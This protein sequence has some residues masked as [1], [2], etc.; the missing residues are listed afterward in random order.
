MT[1]QAE[2]DSSLSQLEAQTSQKAAAFL[3]CHNNNNNNNNTPTTWMAMMSHHHLCLSF[4][5][6]LWSLKHQFYNKSDNNNIIKSSLSAAVGLASEPADLHR[7]IIKCFIHPV[8]SLIWLLL[9]SAFHQPVQPR[10]ACRQQRAKRA[11]SLRSVAQVRHTADLPGSNW[12]NSLECSR[13]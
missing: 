6:Q 10:K 4:V 9:D 3:L 7:L 2:M 13:D 11:E 5:S 1:P 8:A 12:L